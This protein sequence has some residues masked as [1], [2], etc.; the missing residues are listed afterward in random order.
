LL[1]YLEEGFLLTF[2]SDV[3]CKTQL[4]R[5][6]LQN[7]TIM[8]QNKVSYLEQLPL[9]EISM[10]PEEGRRVVVN[11]RRRR[12]GNPPELIEEIFDRAT[13]LVIQH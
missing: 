3:A 7:I 1:E 4:L 5:I 6:L 9:L 10:N 13:P 8:N 2:A 11:P 12:L